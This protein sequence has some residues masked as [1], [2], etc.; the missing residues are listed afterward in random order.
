MAEIRKETAEGK[1]L[2]SSKAKTKLTDEILASIQGAGWCAT[3]ELHASDKRIQSELFDVWVVW[4]EPGHVDRWC[5]VESHTYVDDDF[6]MF[7]L[8]VPS[9]GY[10]YYNVPASQVLVEYE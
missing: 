3:T 8:Y 5:T 1:E 10:I 4:R 9:E 6:T 2:K 7:D